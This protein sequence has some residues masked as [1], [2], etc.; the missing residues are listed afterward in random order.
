M[1]RAVWKIIRGCCRSPIVLL[2]LFS[3]LASAE[4]TTR[5]AEIARRGAQVMPFS[6]EKTQHQ[7]TK[8]DSGGI[9]R[10]ISRAPLNKTEINLIR[11]HLEQLAKEFKRGDFSGPET[12][13]GYAMPGLA[14]L[15]SAKPGTLNITYSL[16][17]LGARLSLDS[18]DA[19]LI[20]AVHEWFDAQL[21]DHGHDAR[22]MHCP[23]HRP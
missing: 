7:F 2:V 3:H 22:E 21:H 12:I 11:Q 16:E 13:H 14:T 23:H 18:K 15:R 9:Q 10:V 6:L 20:K 19:V 1:I 8:T 5:Q 17:P 4:D